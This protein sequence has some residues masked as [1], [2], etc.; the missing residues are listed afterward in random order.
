MYNY[1]Y[2]S[3]VNKTFVSA[4]IYIA[5]EITCISKCWPLPVKLIYYYVRTQFCSTPFKCASVRHDRDSGC[6]G[7][8]DNVR[9]KTKT[10]LNIIQFY[11]KFVI[12]CCGRS[13][14]EL[15]FSSS[16]VKSDSFGSV[17]IMNSSTFVQEIYM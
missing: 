17:S 11:L 7:R 8:S 16:P 14:A 10:F 5:T 6:F 12:L 4:C 9:V 1:N 3:V 2:V 15:I 13:S